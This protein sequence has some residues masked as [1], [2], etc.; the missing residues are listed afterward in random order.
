LSKVHIVIPDS[1]AH[2][3]YSNKRYTWL[4]N[5]IADVKPDVVVD[6]GDWFDM[7]SLC[8]YDQGTKGFEGRRYKLD[9]QAGCEAQDRLLSIVRRQKQ[10]LPRFV[11]TLG[12]HENR[13]VKAIDRDPVLEGTIGL[14]DLQS[15]EYKWE[16]IPF[17]DI[18]NID[19]INYSHYFVSGVLGRAVPN[20]TQ[21]LMK[22]LDS[23]TMGHHHT[24]DYSRR[25][26]AAGK[27]INA[28]V[29]GVFQ[30]YQSGYAG[31]ANQI[32]DKGVVIKR[33]V[34]KGN[35]DIEWVSLE[36]LKK[37]YG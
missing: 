24:F 18:V 25:S 34:E 27:T 15:R 23:C 31:Q 5:L 36:R 4:G 26:T 37:A 7:P 9:I 17:L 35:Y 20:A 21:L 29:C 16:E 6:I 10:K 3:S 19:G 13:I 2:P 1:H 11:R 8:S 28:L 33:N 32:W 14:S 30:D 22:Q 12:N